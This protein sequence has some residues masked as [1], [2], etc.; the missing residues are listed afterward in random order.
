MLVQWCGHC[1]NLAPEYE[2]AATELLKADPPIVLAKVDATEEENKALA[3]KFGVKG[4]PTLKVQLVLN[5]GLSFQFFL[6]GCLLTR[7]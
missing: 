4:F 3:E 1:K 2:K 5:A 6:F 7:V